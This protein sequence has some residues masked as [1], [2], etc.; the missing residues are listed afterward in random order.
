LGIV[1]GHCQDSN[2]QDPG[3]AQAIDQAPLYLRRIRPDPV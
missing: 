1:V 3:T 2:R